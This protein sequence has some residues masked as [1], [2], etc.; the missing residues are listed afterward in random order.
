MTEDPGRAE[1]GEGGVAL[2]SQHFDFI[3]GHTQRGDGLS[4]SVPDRIDN[5]CGLESLCLLVTLA[6]QLR[7]AVGQRRG[8]EERPGPQ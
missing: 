3:T 7:D 2:R 8:G 6:L 4:N 5:A 1:G